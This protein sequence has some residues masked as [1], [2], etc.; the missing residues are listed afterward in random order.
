[1]LVLG[2]TLFGYLIGELKFNEACGNRTGL[3]CKILEQSFA[4]HKDFNYMYHVPVKKLQEI[5]I[6][7]VSF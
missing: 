7:F 3:Q 2:I 5:Q 4:E 6:I 1:M